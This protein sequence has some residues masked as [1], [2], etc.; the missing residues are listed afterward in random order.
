MC[1][2]SSNEITT[3]RPLSVPAGPVRQWTHSWRSVPGTGGDDDERESSSGTRRDGQD[4]S[5]G[6]RADW[7]RGGCQSASAHGAAAPPF[8]WEQPATW[9]EAL[10]GVDA[11]YV[12]LPPGSGG[13]RRG[14]CDPVI[15]RAGGDERRPAPGAAVR[16]RRA[17]GRALRTDRPRLRRRM[18]AR[19][20]QL[21]RA[22]LQRKLPARRRARGRS[23]AAGRR[24]R[25]TVRRRRRHRRRRGRGAHRGRARRAALRGHGPA[26]VDVRRGGR[27]D[28]PRDRTLHSL[29]AGVARGV[30]RGAARRPASR[31]HG[32]AHHLSVRRGPRRPERLGRRRR[33]ARAGP[34]AARLRR[35]RQSAAASGV[36]NPA[37]W[38][39]T[40]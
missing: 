30:C 40:A 14:R 37:S 36:W 33:H 3:S 25:R 23:G 17:G 10:H 38:A 27:R 5:P 7:L 1:G 22:E 13:A 35:L 32:R 24:R 6:G 26:S 16:P 39:R 31:A 28:H 29:R 11:V 8:D 2:R 18:D 19:A 21:V 20:R 12:C 15:H 34:A 9:R 4:R